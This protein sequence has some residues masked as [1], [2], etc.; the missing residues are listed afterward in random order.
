MKVNAI[1]KELE[2]AAPRTLAEEWD[3]VGLIAGNPELEV[4]RAM[5]ALDC[6]QEVISAAQ[7]SGCELILTHHPLYI[8][9][10]L[11]MN[12][13]CAP[14]RRVLRLLESR[15]AHIALHTNADAAEGGVN[16][17]LAERL[18]LAEIRP[19]GETGEVRFAR[20]GVLPERMTP[21]TFAAYAKEQLHA[22]AVKYNSGGREI[23]HV[24]LMGGAGGDIFAEAAAFGVDAYLT[25][26]VKHHLFTEAQDAGITLCDAGH[27]HTELPVV[28]GFLTPLLERLGVEVI[29]FDQGGLVRAI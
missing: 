18:R 24:A 14:S 26:D 13:G 19:L 16:D 20:V 11:Q 4:R 12:G 2:R 15:I 29:P 6:T 17:L 10:P 25:G 9:P 22:P 21:A 28:A 8:K 7:E 3:N 5:T 1:L 27:L 23:L